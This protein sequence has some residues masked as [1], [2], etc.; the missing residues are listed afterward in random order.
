MVTT[1]YS[2]TGAYYTPYSRQTQKAMRGEDVEKSDLLNQMGNV[3]L[4]YTKAY[5]LSIYLKS[6]IIIAMEKA[7]IKHVDVCVKNLEE[8][9]VCYQASFLA[10]LTK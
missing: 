10:D 7:D 8:S 2:G 4:Y 5:I 1:S 6:L 3:G 9:L